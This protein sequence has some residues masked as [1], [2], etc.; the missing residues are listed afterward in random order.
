M[1]VYTLSTNLQIMELVKLPL[2]L[3]HFKEHKQWDHD[4]SFMD[5]MYLHYIQDNNKYGDVERDMEMPFKTPLHSLGL[6]VGFTMPSPDFI[7]IHKADYIEPKLI[8]SIDSSIYSSQYPS[9]IWHP[10]KYC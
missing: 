8:Y 7:L 9:S 2:L 10:P 1:A 5:F 6:Y 3:E 4:I